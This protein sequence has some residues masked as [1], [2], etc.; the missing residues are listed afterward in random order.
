M[1]SPKIPILN[2]KFEIRIFLTIFR[3][4]FWLMILLIFL[5]I[6]GGYIFFRYTKPVY[7][8]TAVLQ[9]KFENKSNQIFGI[10][11]GLI[12]Q[13]LAPAIE[14]LRSNEFLK[15]CISELPVD[16]SYFNQ[17][18][19][20]SSE[21]Y[22]NAPF[23]VK[24]R[25]NNRAILDNKIFVEFD[26][27]AC[28]I[29]YE[30]LGKLY[31][32]TISLNQWHSLYGLD[33]FI[34]PK[35]VSENG[36]EFITKNE[37]NDFYFIIY[38][39]STILRTISNNLVVQ[40][41]SESAGTILITYSDYNA[42]KAADI[43]NTI[44]EKF[45]RF[46]EDRKKESAINIVSYIDQQMD[47]VLEQLNE[48]EKALHE[49]R[50][51]NNIK[52]SDNRF[53]QNRS[54][55]LTN[56]MGEMESMIF[57]VDVE[58]MTLNKISEM[59][60]RDSESLNIY[61]MLALIT[62]HQSERF[63]VSM[64]NSILNLERQKNELLFDVTINN[65]KI[66]KI[67][68]QIEHQK[69]TIVDFILWT[70]TRLET[71]K[72]EYI[73][74]LNDLENRM[75]TDSVYDE[76]EYA[77]LLRIHS[78][79]ID[80]YSKLIKTK[81]ETMISQAGYVSDNLILERAIIAE[82]PEY[83]NLLRSILVAVIIAISISLIFFAFKYL[84]YNRVNSTQDISEYSQI[85][86]LGGIPAAKTEMKVSQILLFERPK[87]M[88]SEAFRNI[89]TNL[90]FFEKKDERCRVIAISSTIAGEGKTFIALNIGAIFA[91]NDKKVMLL[92][93]DLR[94][95]RLHQAF[96]VSNDVGITNILISNK[97]FKDCINKTEYDNYDFITSGPLPPNP[98]EIVL[99]KA[100][101]NLIE[102]LKA[103]YDIIIID[104]PPVG[105]VTDGHISFKIADNPIYIM[106]SGIS[107][108]SFIENI[109]SFKE[110]NQLNKLSIVLNG[111]ERS[112][113]RFGYGYKT[114]YGYQYGYSGYGYGY[115]YLTKIHN[116]YYGEE[117]E[118]KKGLWGFISGIFKK[119]DL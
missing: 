50:R 102:E 79:H 98:A 114:G 86:V 8:S 71:Q 84:F 17:G 53:I 90:E 85:P 23:E 43:T 26:T 9:I 49:F 12:E 14:L 4:L 67:N 87:S 93:L 66:V 64:L 99:T 11:S 110:T 10:R 1:D 68:A 100:F 107:P 34:I 56:T 61:E 88:I 15:S 40:T 73:K 101:E 62:G 60:K 83:P 118:E 95:P 28:G 27:N 78:I 2:Q 36:E 45:I 116:S 113:I 72:S 81:A 31:K 77:K 112:N 57:I 35:T 30:L 39:Q 3:K 63:L 117:P 51:N 46:D 21:L 106:R 69:N 65:H 80:F 55:L 25:I 115:G 44:A 13:E 108:K 42:R 111:I 38:N 33:I 89:R 52:T 16:V 58:I 41:L 70:L 20:L 75:F 104:T 7:K 5:A 59:L 97:T 22:G 76:I 74:R 105:I 18:T 6:A 82:S 37:K 96:N 119:R 19:F 47:L 103:H 54:T 29:S 109:N 94:K 48:S 32:Y 24:Y 91:M 92:D